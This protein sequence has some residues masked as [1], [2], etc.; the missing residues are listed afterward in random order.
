MLI[1]LVIVAMFAI[2]VFVFVRQKPFGKVPEGNRLERIKKSPNYKNGAFANQTE[3]PMMAEEASYLR[4]LKLYLFQ[5]N[6]TEPDTTVPS[7]KTDLN[8]YLTEKP[9]LT[10]FGHSTLLIR[11][12]GATILVDPVFSQRASPVS[13]AGSKNY[14][15]T[16]IYSISDLPAID[17]VLITHDHYDHLDYETIDQLKAQT[18]KFYTPLGVGSHLEY[19]GVPAEKIREFDWWE[20]ENITSEI[21]L[22]ATPARHFSGRGITDRNK[23]LWTSYVIK[24]ADHSLYLGGDSGYDKHYKEIGEKYGPFDLVLLEA[25]QYHEYWP[26]I[27]MMPEE[28][29]QACI[30]LKGK[31]LLPIHWAKFTLALHAWNDP[32]TRVAKK[33]KESEVKLSTPMIGEKIIVDSVY[34]NKTWWIN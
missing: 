10:W 29:V 7:V 20:S 9:V 13:Y 26:F 28:T 15:G 27:H 33:A 34:P 8:S 3:T 2:A 5:E 16:D 21:K 18:G 6:K 25:G 1:F 31:V 22:I 24:T 14:K 12:A 17:F 19:W 4:L 11:I 23:T 30:D 32:I